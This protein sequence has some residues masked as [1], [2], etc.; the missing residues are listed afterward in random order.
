MLLTDLRGKITTVNT[1]FAGM[2]GYL[3][4]D[5]VGATLREITHPD[6]P[7]FLIGELE[8]LQ[9]DSEGH[10]R[11][12][13]EKRYLHRDGHAVWV[14]VDAAALRGSG[15]GFDHVIAHVT[16]V[17]ALRSAQDEQERAR[18]ELH[19]SEAMFRAV[20]K[21]AP[22]GVFVVDEH[23]ENIYANDRLCA[24][25]G[26]TQRQMGNGGWMAAIHPDDRDQMVARWRDAF[27]TGE[28]AAFEHRIVRPDGSLRWVL[29][30]ISPL[31]GPDPEARRWLG[32]LTDL[33][34][35]RLVDERYRALF[36]GA[37]DAVYTAELPGTL[38]SV[39][40][41]AEELSGYTRAELVGMNFFDLIVPEQHEWVAEAIKRA[42]ESGEPTPVLELNLVRKD[43]T[44]RFIEVNGRVLPGNGLPPRLEGIARDTTERHQLEHK[45]R[46]QA[47][48]DGL[49]GLANR[50]LFLDRLDQALARARRDGT[51]IAVMLLDV[52]DLKLVNDSLGHIAGDQLLIELA[53]RLTGILRDGETVARL[54]GD[55]FALVAE[56][57]EGE[58]AVIALAERVQSTFALPF[59]LEERE[60]S[61][62]ASLG[63]ALAGPETGPQALLRDADTAM[64]RAK[65]AGQGGYEFFDA[66]MRAH[67]IRRFTLATA[68]DTAI[69][70]HRL[71]V[72]FQPI[73]SLAHREVIAVEALVRWTDPVLGEL[74]PNEFVPLAEQNGLIV[75]LGRFVLDHAEREAAHWKDSHPAGLPLGV[76]VNLSPR[77]LAQEDFVPFVRRT[78]R[79]YGLDG[80]ELA[81]ELTERI[82]IDDRDPRVAANLEKLAA[83]GIRLLLDDFGIGY[84]ALSSLKRFPLAA[85]KIDR[86]FIDA[87]KT[88]DEA[89]VTRAII[90]LGNALGLLVIA[91]GIENEQQIAQLVELGCGAGQGFHL[92]L[93][94]DAA[95]IDAILDPS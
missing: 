18:A 86:Y 74:D 51:Q 82:M 1:A 9:T 38:T 91:E 5:L 84:S 19:A 80:S 56:H 4:D 42:M 66:E 89:V 92:A 65:A 14:H 29:L 68:L 69:R 95:G 41:A 73:F 90:G 87:L 63:I 31:E 81:F 11:S 37:R 6:D 55:E 45:L 28:A 93:P 50:T 12:I 71:L 52:D 20:A 67:V 43:G 77:E 8:R 10:E 83:E 61:L 27:A 58:A 88:G 30:N 22:V 40:S 33:T 62:R 3:P 32:V 16:D 35:R 25:S 34:D 53:S 46:E 15:G 57:L 17:S 60:Q 48:Q 79:A 72:D 94:Q 21:Q 2:L 75:P 7:V 54:G 39:N 26:L 64:Y 76:F 13:F 70:E 49:T 85:V 47:L 23:G 36:D 78:L 44:R 24:L 59:A